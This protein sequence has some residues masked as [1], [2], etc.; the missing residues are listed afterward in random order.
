MKMRSQMWTICTFLWAAIA[1]QAFAAEIVVPSVPGLAVQVGQTIPLPGVESAIVHQFDDGRL[2]VMGPDKGIWSSDGGRTWREG[3]R[4]P[5]DKTTLNLGNGEVLSIYRTS[6]RRA[7]GKY[8]LVQRRSLDNW[9]TVQTETAL[10]DTPEATTTGGDAGDQHEGLLMHHGAIKLKN[11]DLMATMFGNYQGDRIPAAGYPEE[12]KLHKYRTVVVFSSDNGRT[13]A[14]PVTV[15]YDRQLARGSDPDS[16]V[17]TTAVVP[18]VTQEGFCEAD[19]V[20]AA[21]GDIL[22]AMRSGGRIG[23]RKAPIFPTPL[24]LS[25]SQDE[26]RTWTA[27]VPIADRGVCPYLVTLQNGV[28]VCSYARPGGWLIFSDDDGESWKGAIQFCSSDSYCNIIEVAP[29][30]VLVIYYGG[31]S[32]TAAYSGTFFSVNRK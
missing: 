12:L 26:G 28:I 29:N 8:E 27:P 14:N 23:I 32:G 22:C 15:A 7:D 6:V 10:L 2:V 3:P 9:T 11:G 1:G 24:Y 4:G 30:Q 19:L 13:W 20:R 17:Q 25:R 5:D 31:N 21:N 16:S 18:A